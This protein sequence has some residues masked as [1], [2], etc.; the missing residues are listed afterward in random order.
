MV[1]HFL[2]PLELHT[3]AKQ[4]G[5]P[6]RPYWSAIVVDGDV[7]KLRLLAERQDS[8]TPVHVDWVRFSVIRRNVAALSIDTLFPLP[9]NLAMDIRNPTYRDHDASVYD[10]SY[11]L[12]DAARRMP[13]DDQTDEEFIVGNEAFELAERVATALGK[14]FT[15]FSE[16]KKGIDFYRF[17]WSI[18]L[19]GQEVGWV[20]CG[21]NVR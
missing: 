12:Q 13:L 6:D 4:K 17:R 9:K 8:K 21:R 3:V 2:P 16:P 20:G 14:A 1:R 5:T 19:N 15:V 18:E 7:V 10:S 11:L